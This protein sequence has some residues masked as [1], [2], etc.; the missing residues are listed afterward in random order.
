MERDT[1]G[2]SGYSLYQENVLVFDIDPRHKDLQEGQVIKAVNGTICGLCFS[3]D[4]RLATRSV[5][6]AVGE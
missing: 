5:V 1:N 2:S 3:E 4:I 6:V